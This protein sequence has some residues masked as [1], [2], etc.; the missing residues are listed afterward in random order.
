[1]KYKNSIKHFWNCEKVHSF[2]QETW[3]QR[4]SSV[5]RSLQNRW[6]YAYLC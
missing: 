3:F 5:K 2:V 6:T 4:R 1:M